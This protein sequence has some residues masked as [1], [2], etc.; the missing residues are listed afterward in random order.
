MECWSEKEHQ[1]H[2]F[3][4]FLFAYEVLDLSLTYWAYLTNYWKNIQEFYSLSEVLKNN[5]ALCTRC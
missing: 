3:I 4:A 2:F 1:K 5:I